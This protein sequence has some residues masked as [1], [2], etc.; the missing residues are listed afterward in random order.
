MAWDGDYGAK[1]YGTS[2][3][4]VGGVVGWAGAMAPP[5]Q[6]DE[7]ANFAALYFRV[8]FFARL[9]V[10]ARFGFVVVTVVELVV[11]HFVD[12]VVGFVGVDEINVEVVD[13]CIGVDFIVL[14]SYLA[15]YIGYQIGDIVR[16]RL[17]VEMKVLRNLKK[18]TSL[19]LKES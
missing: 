3:G 7:D 11:V 15:L 8:F 18:M 10:V 5:Y 17:N 4:M 12:I 2:H 14:V 6:V 16:K 19:G 1:G 13:V 9:E